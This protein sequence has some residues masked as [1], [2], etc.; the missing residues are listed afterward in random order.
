VT[1]AIE[2][3]AVGGVPLLGFAFGCAA[4][5]Q[6]IVPS[7]QQFSYFQ[8]GGFDRTFLSFM[9]VDGDGSV[10]V[11]RLTAKPHVTAGAGGF[12]DI[13]AHARHIVFSGYMTAGGLELDLTGGRLT[14]VKEGRA[15]KFVPGLEHV[16][17]SGRMGRQRGQHVLF[18][19]ERAVIELQPDGLTVTEIAP[20]VDLERDVLAQAEL[21]LR[22]APDLREMD[23]RLFR[24]EPMGLELSRRER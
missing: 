14:I 17:F 22:V 23:A 24:P 21:P 3:G 5:A 16:T 4:N 15:R 2:Q 20:G 9:Q 13:T 1:W 8:G 7:P 6:A 12:V 10:N 18:V 11:S 19:T